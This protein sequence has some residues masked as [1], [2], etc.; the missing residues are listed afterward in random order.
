MI[1]ERHKFL[2]NRIPWNIMDNRDEEKKLT[3][4]QV[5]ILERL[6]EE[7]ICFVDYRKPE[8][9][10]GELAENYGADETINALRD[11][12]NNYDV[13]RL[14][15]RKTFG[16]IDKSAYRVDLEKARELYDS[17]QNA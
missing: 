12:E 2:N 4:C 16:F 9:Q 15:P 1:I 6:V 13:L 10:L 7:G 3:D 8:R 17:Y 5:K 11:L 14:K